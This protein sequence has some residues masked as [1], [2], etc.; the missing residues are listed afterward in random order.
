MHTTADDPTKY[1]DE[2]LVQ[3]WLPKDPLLRM[4]RYLER[5]NFWD[6]ARQ[7]ELDIAIK[8][9]IDQAVDA[10]EAIKD[11][12]PDAPF[13]H[14]FGTAQPATEKQRTEFLRQLEQEGI[15]GQAQSH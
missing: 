14:F 1:R 13:D 5:K 9:S 12:K 6:E 8:Q 10:A 11:Y 3:E 7:Q 4:R 2:K 15:H